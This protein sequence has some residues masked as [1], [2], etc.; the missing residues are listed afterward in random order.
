MGTRARI[1]VVCEQGTILSN[2]VNRD[3]SD[4]EHQLNTQWPTL[5]KAVALITGGGEISSLWFGKNNVQYYHDVVPNERWKCYDSEQQYVDDC[6]QDI[7]I[8]FGYL[9]KNGKWVTI[10]GNND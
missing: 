6:N 1:A 7:F 10:Y 3:G 9:F 5:E 4:L 2:W 8:E